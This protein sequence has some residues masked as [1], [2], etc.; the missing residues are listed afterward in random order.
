MARTATNIALPEAS[1]ATGPTPLRGTASV[2]EGI[3]DAAVR[4]FLERGFTETTIDDIA[5]EAGISRR[6]YFRYFASKDDAVLEYMSLLAGRITRAL[7]S[8]PAEEPGL[9]ALQNAMREVLMDEIQDAPLAYSLTRLILETPALRDRQLG[10]N[11][12]MEARVAVILARRLGLPT[13]DT[14][15][16]LVAAL[17][18]DAL[19]IGI[20]RWLEHEEDGGS[21][22]SEIDA[23]FDSIREVYRQPRP[24]IAAADSQQER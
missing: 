12:A 4:L 1:E 22:V 6:T 2:R 9:S 16:R 18:T 5:A 17:G 20:Q 8:R 15:A 11:A 23:V 13:V 14:T 7:E 21:M 24:V 10:I 19:D 3:A